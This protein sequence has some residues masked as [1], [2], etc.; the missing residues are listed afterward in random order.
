MSER[1]ASHLFSWIPVFLQSCWTHCALLWWRQPAGALSFG[2]ILHPPFHRHL[3]HIWEKPRLHDPQTQ[4]GHW[5]PWAMQS[6]TCPKNSIFLEGIVKRREAEMAPCRDNWP[7]HSSSTLHNP[8]LGP[9]AAPLLS[10]HSPCPSSLPPE[11]EGNGDTLQGHHMGPVL[12]TCFPL[13]WGHTLGCVYTEKTD[14]ILS[15]S[16]S[17]TLFSSI[18][19]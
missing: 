2:F 6:P 19:N 1:Q 13:P 17:T 14:F 18:Y 10:A 5:H 7:I 16:V 11:A 12:P 9:A 4:L 8:F 3:P 15:C